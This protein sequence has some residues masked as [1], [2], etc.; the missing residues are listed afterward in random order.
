MPRR[1]IRL[2]T[3]TDARIQ[4]AAKL[5]GYSSPSA[6]LRAAIKKELS[7]RTEAIGLSTEQIVGCVQEVR[8]DV[9]RVERAQQALFALVDSLAKV[10]LTCVPEPRG[11]AMEPALAEAR[12]RHARLLNNAGHAMRSDSLVAM[13]ELISRGEK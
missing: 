11:T 12:N 8:Q 5:R 3:E 6:F 9:R 2:T 13:E 10:F 4:S 1:T 7:E